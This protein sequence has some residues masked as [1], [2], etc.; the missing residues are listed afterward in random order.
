V[1]KNLITSVVMVDWGLTE[2]K[3]KEYLSIL[4]RAG[5]IIIN[6]DVVQLTPRE[7]ELVLKEVRSVDKIVQ[8]IE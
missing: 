5:Y 1:S 4:N 8:D 3:V 2:K 6:G 7:E